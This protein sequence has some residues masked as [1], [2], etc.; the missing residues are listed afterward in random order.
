[1]RLDFK[2]KNLNAEFLLTIAEKSFDR[3]FFTRDREQKYLTIAWNRG[4]AQKVSVDEMEFV[5]PENSILPLM[6][7][8]SFRFENAAQI[9]AWQF[10]REFYCIVDHDK[11][12]SCVGFLFYG[13]SNV[14]F[15]RLGEAETRKIALLLEVFKDEFADA[16]DI[17][18]EM[19][20]MLLVRLIIILTRI[21]KAQYLNNVAFE[22]NKFDIVRQ[23]NLMVE[24]FYRTAHDVGFYAARLNKSPKTLSNYFA[25]YGHK[26]PLQIIQER[27]ALEAKRLFYY[28]DK[29]SKEIA[30]ELGFDDAAHFSRFFKNQTGKSPSEFKRSVKIRQAAKLL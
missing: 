6:V 21:A 4:A 27:I 1:M 16:D 14:M 20:R 8:Q 30:Y 19:L 9:T 13:S 11:E 17:Q 10:N 25:L 22:E 12:V 3:A 15:L 5:F 7:N 18:S 2:N 23:F 29:T 26:T 28:T 24:N